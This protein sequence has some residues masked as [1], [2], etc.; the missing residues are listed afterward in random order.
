VN[1]NADWMFQAQQILFS[2]RLQTT[3]NDELGP[4]ERNMYKVRP[5]ER[6][7][8]GT[9][10]AWYAK[11]KTE[12]EWQ[13]D[14]LCFRHPLR[15]NQKKYFLLHN[16]REHFDDRYGT[17]MKHTTVQKYRKGTNLRPG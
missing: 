11:L 5:L 2:Q 8:K 14:L 1:P 9:M 10:S 12:R 3:C 16:D 17:V 4:E 6:R 13:L 15:N 7:D